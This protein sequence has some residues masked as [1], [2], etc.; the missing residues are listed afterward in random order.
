M[1]CRA[2]DIAGN[3]NTANAAYSV[4]QRVLAH[5]DPVYGVTT[6][7]GASVEFH[8]PVEV[9][10]V[11][12][13]VRVRRTELIDG[14]EG[15][16]LHD[17]GRG[18]RRE[19]EILDRPEVLKVAAE[20]AGAYGVL[21]RVEVGDRLLDGPVD[22]LEKRFVDRVRRLLRGVIR[23]SDGDADRIKPG[24]LDEGK[25]FLLQAHSPLA[26]LR[27]LQRIAEVDATAEQAVVL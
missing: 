22:A 8:V 15:T 7:F 3:T 25:V 26:F 4:I 20:M 9:A 13:S 5:P 10:E 6:G 21:E 14:S 24:L 17:G 23:P 12:Y 16:G 19:Y 1:A 18:L 2:T 11:N 27:R